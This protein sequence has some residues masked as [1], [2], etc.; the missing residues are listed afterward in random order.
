MIMNVHSL[1]VRRSL[2]DLEQEHAAGNTKP[3]DDLMRAWKGIKELPAE[4]ERSFFVLGGYHGE[5]FRGA[6]WGSNAYWGGYCHHGNV[7]FPIWH[8]IY[9]Y[10][11]EQALRTIPGCGDVTL[12]FWDECSAD[13]L[14]R[15]IPWSLTAETYDLDG[16]TIPNPLRSYVFPVNVVDQI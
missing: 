13:S 8:R 6:G 7:L 16:E 5:P 3:L 11:L 1:R 10:K 9:V 4:D 2:T 14:A 12:P 15:G